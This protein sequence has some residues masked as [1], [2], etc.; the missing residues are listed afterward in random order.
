MTDT[1]IIRTL[2]GR[3]LDLLNPDPAHVSLREIAVGLARE[4]R[5]AR[6]CPRFY[7]VAEHSWLMAASCVRHF[8]EV[9]DANRERFRRLQLR[10]LLHDAS[11][12]YLGD[13]PAPIKVCSLMDGYR[14]VE[15]KLQSAIY[16][17]WGLAYN[18]PEGLGPM[19]HMLDRA[20]RSEEV[21]VLWGRSLK[22]GSED[23]GVQGFAEVEATQMYLS[24]FEM[25][26]QGDF[27][28]LGFQG[29]PLG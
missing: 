6:Q 22:R 27:P 26:T 7:S 15:A 18:C 5:Y 24:A 11:E 12:A 17:R 8:G 21:D 1:A 28:F 16:S 25:V 3:E 19:V 20:I 4:C 29:K 2:C 9:L 10:C 14:E 13:L 23:F